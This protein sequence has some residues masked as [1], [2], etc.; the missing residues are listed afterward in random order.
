VAV[1]LIA[2][3]P[4]AYFLARTRARWRVVVDALI[5]LPMV[6]PPTVMGLYLLTALGPRSPL[7]RMTES[8]LGHGFTFSFTGLLIASVII[9]IPFAVRPFVA[10]FSAVSRNLID[11]AHTLGDS[12]LRA[13]FRVVLP[14]SWPGIVSG[15]VL[16]FVHTMGE[17][18]VALMVGGAIPG[19]TATLSISI[20]DSVQSM[21]YGAAHA[22]AAILL[23]AS[24]VALCAV[25]ALE[26]RAVRHIR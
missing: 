22:A 1:L 2:G 24:F 14:L 13:F 9:N 26:R 15:C 8:V 21:D 19:E 11:A 23:T 12:P 5:M 3:L 17:F 25:F 6:L 10:S 20:Y 7:G 16:A 4:L 18:G